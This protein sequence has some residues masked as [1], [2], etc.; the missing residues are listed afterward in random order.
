M[1]KEKL[2]KS[3][4]DCWREIEPS[5][6]KCKER[7]IQDLEAQEIV[8]PNQMV[9]VEEVARRLSVTTPQVRNLLKSKRLRGIKQG[10]YWLINELEVDRYINRLK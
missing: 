7:I 6:I 2:F 1:K 4:A 3:L 10:K 9:R 5:L 8:S